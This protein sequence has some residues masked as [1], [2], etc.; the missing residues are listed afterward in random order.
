MVPSRSFDISFRKY[1]QVFNMNSNSDIAI[2]SAV[3]FVFFSF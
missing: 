1:S 2:V 3:Y